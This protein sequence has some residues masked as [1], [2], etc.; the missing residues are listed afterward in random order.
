MRSFMAIVASIVAL[1]LLSGCTFNGGTPTPTSTLQP[2]AG[3]VL[4]PAPD[5]NTRCVL[6]TKMPALASFTSGEE[7][8]FCVSADLTC[9][10]FQGSG[11]IIYDPRELEPLRVDRGTLI[12]ANY[13][14]IAP[15]NTSNVDPSTLPAGMAVVPFAFTGTPEQAPIQPQ[16]GELLAVRFKVKQPIVEPHPVYILNNLEFLQLR[17]S[18]GGRLAFD[19]ESLEVQQ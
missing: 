10:L 2:A 13:V 15:L 12:P 17:N 1:L 3:H 16:T 14:F 5:Q 18:S 11:R 7:F 19:L 8:D 6:R 4:N 9:P